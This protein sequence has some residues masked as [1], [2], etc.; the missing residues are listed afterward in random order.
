[1]SDK[2]KQLDSTIPDVPSKNSEQKQSSSSLLSY[3]ANKKGLIAAVL[4]ATGIMLGC[5]KAACNCAGCEVASC[6][7]D[8]DGNATMNGCSGCGN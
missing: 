3:L 2:L 1:M 8:K 7:V 5:D 4:L 6:G